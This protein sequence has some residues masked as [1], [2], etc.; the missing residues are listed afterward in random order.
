MV[1]NELL[2]LSRNRDKN[3]MEL[4]GLLIMVEKFAFAVK[5][6]GPHCKKK[7]IQQTH[8]LTWWNTSNLLILININYSS[9][10]NAAIEV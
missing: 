4:V 1:N 3:S 6:P 7:L 5:F 2:I 10:F 9:S 8:V